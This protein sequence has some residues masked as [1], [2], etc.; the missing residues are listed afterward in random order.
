MPSVH[1]HL[2]PEILER[3]LLGQHLAVDAVAAVEE[4]LLACDHCIEEAQDIEWEILLI[5]ETLRSLARLEPQIIRT[6]AAGILMSNLRASG[7]SKAQYQRSFKRLGE[8]MRQT[9]HRGCRSLVQ[10]LR[11][12]RATLFQSQT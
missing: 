6:T 12:V 9:I 5:R 2:E 8:L 10:T 3:Y 1:H 7:I 4:H 11:G